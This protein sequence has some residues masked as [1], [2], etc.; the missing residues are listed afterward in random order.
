MPFF[1]Y[2]RIIHNIQ[3]NRRRDRLIPLI[4]TTIMYFFAYFLLYK[5][6]TPEYVRLFILAA[7]ILVLITCLLSIK[8]KISAHMVGI[9]GIVGMIIAL[10]SQVTGNLN[11]YLFASIFVAGLVGASRLRLNVHN[12]RQV[13]IGLVIGLIP[14]LFIMLFF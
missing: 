2:Q 7:A 8:W 12:T 5:L 10:Y 4:I 13:Y 1:I 9:G 6:Q 14:T 3:M 11:F